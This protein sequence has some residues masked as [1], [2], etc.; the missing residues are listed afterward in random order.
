MR[1]N[2][3]DRSSTPEKKHHEE[4][5]KWARGGIQFIDPLEVPPVLDL[6]REY[7][8]YY[9]I[10]YEK[11]CVNK[12]ENLTGLLTKEEFRNIL[13]KYVYPFSNEELDAIINLCPM[14]YNDRIQYKGFFNGIRRLGRPKT[15]C[16]LKKLLANNYEFFE[17]YETLSAQNFFTLKRN[18]DLRKYELEDID[19][20][21][22]EQNTGEDNLE[23]FN[24]NVIIENFLVKLSRDFFKTIKAVYP[25]QELTEGL[26]FKTLGIK[27][28]EKVNFIQP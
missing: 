5:D 25:N 18:Y 8:Y 26:I 27:P 7:T 24:N 28:F 6:L 22:L 20:Q 14:N 3:Q 9:S 12:D 23:N 2:R 1:F 4:R 15:Q 16:S 11:H 10:D 13:N 21:A 19:F 17:K